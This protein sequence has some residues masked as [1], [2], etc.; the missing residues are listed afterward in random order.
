MAL[1]DLPPHA[2]ASLVAIAEHGSV[3]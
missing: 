2:L 1:P 3:S